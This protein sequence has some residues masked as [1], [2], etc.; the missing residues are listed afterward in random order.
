MN[1]GPRELFLGWKKSPR[2]LIEPTYYM[3]VSIDRLSAVI[4]TEWGF[5]MKPTKVVPRRK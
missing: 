4:K 1:D 3:N 5:F 2:S